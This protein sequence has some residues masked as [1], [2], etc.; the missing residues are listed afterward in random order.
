[1]YGITVQQVY[2]RCTNFCKIWSVSTAQTFPLNSLYTSH[3][4][5]IAMILLYS[6]IFG[7]VIVL[8]YSSEP[9]KLYCSVI[10]SSCTYLMP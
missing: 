2:V 10:M 5:L 1:M 9:K 4:Y 8:L 7:L 6:Q 3:K